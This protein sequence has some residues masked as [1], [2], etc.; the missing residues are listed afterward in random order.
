MLGGAALSKSGNRVSRGNLRLFAD[1]EIQENR[2]PAAAPEIRYAAFSIIVEVAV[3]LLL[4]P[5]RPVRSIRMSRSMIF[6]GTY[7]PIWLKQ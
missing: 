4:I 3:A 5:S 2:A 1:P 7:F 6:P